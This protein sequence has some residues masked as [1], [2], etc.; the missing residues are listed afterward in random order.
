MRGVSST[1]TRGALPRPVLRLRV[2]TPLEC[3]RHRRSRDS[4]VCRGGRHRAF[5][6]TLQFPRIDLWR[7]VGM[8]RELRTAVHPSGSDI[9]R[10]SNTLWRTP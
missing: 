8:L 1:H 5:A 7:E 9:D 6:A 4:A 10:L 2:A 3:R